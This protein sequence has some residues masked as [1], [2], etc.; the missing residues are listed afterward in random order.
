MEIDEDTYS[1]IF[2]AL[3][4]PVRRKI[5]RH[6][7]ENLATY[8]EILNSLN[9]DTGFLNYHLESLGSLITKNQEDKYTLS[10]F[11]T[12]ALKL[13]EGV[14]EPIR[15]TRSLSILGFRLNPVHISLAFIVVLAVSNIYS[16]YAYH[17]LSRE[18]EN[19][20]GESLI[21]AKGCLDESINILN[22]TIDAGRVEHE[23]WD[24]MYSDLIHLSHYYKL[25][26]FLDGPHYQQWS[27]ISDATDSLAIFVDD[28]SQYASCFNITYR[29]TS[30][31]RARYL[32]NIRDC[33]LQIERMAFPAEVIIGSN[34]RVK[35]FDKEITETMVTSIQLD[36]DVESAR[37][38][39][40]LPTTVR[41]Y[42]DTDHP[43]W[44]WIPDSG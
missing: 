33:L 44:F 2:S 41:I 9:V 5:I 28:L 14:E 6:L 10:E 18:H 16:G 37:R 20:L 7:G 13:M 15:R 11:G 23:L 8:T 27:Q 40:N 19:A 17:S 26:S 36:I 30:V 25:I 32:R 21:Q 22:H 12:A 3:K 24:V 35:V 29:N 39:F 34:P 1:S 42:W 43:R 4:H 31:G 38:A